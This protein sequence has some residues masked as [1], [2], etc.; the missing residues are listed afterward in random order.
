MKLRLF[1]VF[2]Y[3]LFF[4]VVILITIGICF[5][6]S[7]GFNEYGTNVSNE[8]IKQ[9][10]FASTG[11][12]LLIFF[13]IIDYRKYR[14]FMLYLFL[15]LLLVLV[16]TMFF[17]AEVNNARSWI[18]IGGI[19]LQPS[20]L[21]KIVFILFF[22]KELEDTENMEPLK[23]FILLG[24]IMALPAGLILMQP[25]LGTASVYIPIFL[26]MC[27]VA[28]LPLRY[29]MIV[30]CT[31][32]LTILF[33]ILPVYQAEIAQK[34]I[35][36]ITILTNMRLRLIVIVCLSIV[37]LLSFT[38]YFFLKQKYFYWISY[39]SG[40][41]IASLLLSIVAGKVLQGYQ[42][43]RLIIFIDPESD[44]TGTGWNIRQSKLAI[45]SGN[46]LGKGFLKGNL[47]HGRYLPERSTDF[48]FSLLSEEWGFVGGL[49]IFS[50]YLIVLFRIIFILKNTTNTYGY[51]IATGILFMFFFHFMV[52]VGMVIGLMPITGI[53]LLFLSYGGSSLWTSMI[54]IGILMSIHNRRLDF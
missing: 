44:P 23:R 16:Y 34:T 4:P 27:Y 42:I 18:G 53:P 48:I 6:Y 52:N 37:F 7:S 31:G 51:Y 15:G 21:G 30:L 1:E 10:I 3:L 32:L 40:I 54:C 26:G 24:I 5:I 11:L 45:G 17:G 22:A 25:D 19:G 29:I 12:L 49:A 13:S 46:L 50:L 33:T 41:I 35:Q 14:N 9:I 47:S 38:A 2:D 20:E 28:G 39:V 8:Y 36:A 43:K